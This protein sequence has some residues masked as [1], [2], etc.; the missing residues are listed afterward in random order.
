MEQ[1][2]KLK[3][4]IQ[5]DDRAAYRAALDA[6]IDQNSRFY[7]QQV[8]PLLDACGWTVDEWEKE[9]G[10]RTIEKQMIHT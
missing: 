3:A 8:F 5:T 7:Q 6:L 2:R 10:I 9:T 4:A 1:V